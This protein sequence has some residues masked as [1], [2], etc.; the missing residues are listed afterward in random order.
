MRACGYPRPARSCTW[1]GAAARV[2]REW[3]R[4]THRDRI[5]R[6]QGGA[7]DDIDAVD[8]AGARD[9]ETAEQKRL[10]LA[11]AFLDRLQRE[12]ALDDEGRE[13]HEDALGDRRG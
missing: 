9:E 8:G 2:A 1:Q 3:R 10:R 6:A 5:I 13:G 11:K 7:R 12:R 4:K